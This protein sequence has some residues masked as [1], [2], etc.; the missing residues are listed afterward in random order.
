MPR[1]PIESLMFMKVKSRCDNFYY[2]G[3]L[4]HRIRRVF[5]PTLDKSFSFD[6]VSLDDALTLKYVTMT[7]ASRAVKETWDGDM[8]NYSQDH[9]L[10]L[11]EIG[12]IEEYRNPPQKPYKTDPRFYR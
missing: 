3:M 5:I 6:E 2:L 1:Y 12:K 11:S 7:K 9:P 10:S 8:Y 4:D